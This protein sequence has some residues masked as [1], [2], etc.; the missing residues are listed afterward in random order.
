MFKIRPFKMQNI[1]YYKTLDYI[2]H[3]NYL[4]LK[5]HVYHYLILIP[6]AFRGS[7][8][9]PPKVNNPITVMITDLVTPTKEVVR[10][11][12]IDVHKNCEYVRIPPD[13]TRS[14]NTA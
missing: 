2:Q 8:F 10:A 1:N 3:K 12:Q 6:V 5:Y 7:N 4:F 13:T 9:T 11:E 14:K